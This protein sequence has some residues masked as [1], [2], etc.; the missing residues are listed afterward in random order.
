MGRL[1][2]FNYFNGH[3]RLQIFLHLIGGGFDFLFVVVPTLKKEGEL[4]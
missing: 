4:I 2:T 1:V 3:R